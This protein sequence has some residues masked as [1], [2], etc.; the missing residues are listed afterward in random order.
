M[1]E[2][3]EQREQLVLLDPQDVQV[4]LDLLDQLG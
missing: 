3:L 4:Q 2:E 1:L